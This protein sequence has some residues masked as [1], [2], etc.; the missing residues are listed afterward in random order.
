MG[1]VV[2]VAFVLAQMPGLAQVVGLGFGAGAVGSRLGFVD[3]EFHNVGGD[4]GD[5]VDVNM[6][7]I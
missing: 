7:T 2:D 4:P 3:I 6:H 1:V 5:S